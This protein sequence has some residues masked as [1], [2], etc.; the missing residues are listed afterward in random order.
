MASSSGIADERAVIFQLLEHALE[1]SLECPGAYRALRGDMADANFR[2]T[3]A[4]TKRTAPDPNLADAFQRALLKREDLITRVLNLL[5]VDPETPH[6]EDR[7]LRLQLIRELRQLLAR[8][9]V[10]ALEPDLV[11]LDEFQRFKELL[12]EPDPDNPDDIRNLAGELFR[13]PGARTLLLSATPYK[14]YTLRDETD[15]DHY[16]DF[17]RTTRF[18][19]GDHE[20]AQFET[21]LRAFRRMLTMPDSLSDSQGRTELISRKR[22]VEKRLR[23]FMVRTERLA[24]TGDRNGMLTEVPM[25]EMA[26]TPE[27]VRTYARLDHLSQ[28]LKSG[29]VLDY[30]KS[31]PYLLNFM[32]DY[33]LK[34]DLGGALAKGTVPASVTRLVAETPLL[35]RNALDA[36]E[37][38]DPG[39]ARLRGLYADTIESGAWRLLWVPPSLPYYSGRGA[40]TDEHL[41]HFTKRLVFSSWNVVPDAISMVLSYS[42]E[43]AMMKGR[44]PVARNTAVDRARLR[45]LLAIRNQDGNP[46]TMSTFSLLYPCLALARLLDPLEIVSSLGGADRVVTAAE[47]LNEAKARVAAAL[48]PV[49]RR[50]PGEGPEDQRWYWIAPLLLD[51]RGRSRTATV[52]WMS[53]SAMLQ[54]PGQKEGADD[55]SGAWPD[56]VALAHRVIRDGAGSLQLGRVPSDLI[57]STALL[58]L[59][60]PGTCALRGLGRVLARLSGQP[61]DRADRDTRDA[62]LR[63][64]W[65]FRSLFNVPEVMSLLRTENADA[66]AYWRRTLQEG[67]DG[68]LQAVVDEYLHLLPEWH[69][70]ANQGHAGAARGMA[71]ALH[72]AITMRAVNYSADDIATEHGQLSLSPMHIRVR[73]ALRYGRD[74]IDEQQ[75][76]HRSSAVRA[77][78]NSPFWPFV[79]SS[80]SVGQEGLDFHQYCHAVVHW[81]LPANP[82]DLEQREGRVHRF[83]GLAIRRNVAERNRSHAFRSHHLDPW[84][85]MFNAAARTVTKSAHRDIEPYWVYEGPASIQRYV[86]ALPLSKDGERM[87]RLRKSL[88]AYRLAFGQSRQD[89][90]VAYL[91]D[92]VEPEMLDELTEQLGIDLTPR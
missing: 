39:N 71:E 75:Q 62:A 63:I 48:E 22:R 66:D 8:S 76:L 84:Q 12:D 51:H 61:P 49:T 23:R 90:L 10:R 19:M 68:N 21:E 59:A 18:L 58:G 27:D 33:K 17:L 89:D 73:F 64:A 6:A 57:E 24:V 30:W 79:L 38:I 25:P 20:T 65:G 26:L 16:A 15:D 85:A 86:P 67:F 88:A 28:Q 74:A 44:D 56:H 9:C 52:E 78:F 37:R 83:K 3:V 82:V 77:A 11:I 45:G 41:R 35:S 43:R 42:A 1:R 14:M 87:G 5:E 72:E 81:N 2:Q 91:Q 31:A 50:T 70:L 34:K 7:W 69:G 32:S 4:S 54:N 29:D 80:T 36:Y 92:H 53:S 47:V 40:Y 55:E 13:Q 60:G 46:A